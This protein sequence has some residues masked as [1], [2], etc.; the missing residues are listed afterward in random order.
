MQIETKK[1]FKTLE[2]NYPHLMTDFLEMQTEYMASLNVIYSDLDAALI[3]MVLTQA[4]Y[5]NHVDE[6]SRLEKVGVKNFFNK[7]TI[8]LNSKFFII[9]DISKLIQLPRE[10]VRR[11]R[12]KLIKDKIIF[13]DKKKKIYYLNSSIIDK[14]IVDLQIKNLS[15]FLG[16]FGLTLTTNYLSEKNVSTSDIQKDIENKFLIYLTKFL[17]FQINYFSRCKKMTDIESVFISL[18]I[19]LNTTSQMKKIKD[20]KSPNDFFFNMH[21]L[22]K[23][24]GLNAT[25][26][27]EITKIPRTTVIRKLTNLEKKYAIKKDQFKRYSLIDVPKPKSNNQNIIKVIESNLDNLGIFFIECMKV[28][29]LRN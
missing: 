6:D 24:P 5:K 13:F 19:T 18:L 8:G 23:S 15:K 9:N 22:N 27:A 7:N 14:K 16:R 29:K 10:T 21:E 25:S 28:Y 3:G 4:I 20:N 17:D 1:I 12:E 26:I 11:K 2:N